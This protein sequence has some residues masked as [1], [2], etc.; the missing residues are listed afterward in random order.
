MAL[1]RTRRLAEHL[2]PSQQ[3]AAG[4]GPVSSSLLAV[5]PWPERS[6]APREPGT[7]SWHTFGP[8]SQIVVS[9]LQ[10]RG[11]SVY[12]QTNGEHIID[13]NFTAV[14]CT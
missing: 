7:P 10:A 14:A 3:V 8:A 11:I 13:T 2:H 1:R 12:S 5:S 9:H 6:M 4:D